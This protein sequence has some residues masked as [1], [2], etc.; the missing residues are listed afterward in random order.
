MAGMV[1]GAT[2][3]IRSRCVGNVARAWPGAVVGGMEGVVPTRAAVVAVYRATVAATTA[4][5]SA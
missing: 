3:G 1:G 5:L 2:L 4:G